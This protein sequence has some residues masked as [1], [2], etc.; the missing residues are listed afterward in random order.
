MTPVDASA[1]FT[2]SLGA[3]SAPA[4][5]DITAWQGGQ[6]RTATLDVTPGG[7]PA[8][9]PLPLGW[10]AEAQDFLRLINEYRVANG[11][12]PLALDETLQRAASWMAEDALSTCVATDS[13]SPVHDDSFGR[14][15][16][17]RLSAFGYLQ[18]AGENILWG[19][20][21]SA[22][23]AE[24]SFEGWRTSP[25]HNANMLFGAWTAIG[26][27]RACQDGEC[28]WLTD[29]GINVVDHFEPPVLPPPVRVPDLTVT[30]ISVIA[31]TDEQPVTV[32]VTVTNTGAADTGDGF[33]VHLFLDPVSPPTTATIPYAMAAFP[34]LGP[35][36]SG[37]VQWTVPAGVLAAGPHTLWA[38]VDGH[39]VITEID[40]ENNAASVALTVRPANTPPVAVDDAYS[41][42][43]DVTLA[44]AA[45]GVLGN[46]TD[47]EGNLLTAELVTAWGNGSY[48]QLG[49]G[50]YA[51]RNSPVRVIGLPPVIAIAAGSY[52]SLTIDEDRTVWAWGY[53]ANGQLGTGDFANRNTPVQVIGPGGGVLTDVSAIAG[54]YQHSVAQPPVNDSFAAAIGLALPSNVVGNTILASIEAGEPL[55]SCG[56]IG[57]TLWY[58]IVP[59]ESGILAASMGGSLFDTR[60]A[61]YSGSSLAGLVDVDCDDN[62]GLD[63]ASLLTADVTAGQA[64]YLQV[65]GVSSFPGT[66]HAGVLAL[67]VTVASR[68]VNDDFDAA[69]AVSLGSP[70]SLAGDTARATAESGEPL[71]DCG[72]TGRTVWYALT[73]GADGVLTLTVQN[74]EFQ[75]LLV[76]YAGSAVGDLA[77]AEC[78]QSGPTRLTTN[79][80]G[81]QTY[82][83]QLGGQGGSGGVFTLDS[84]FYPYPPNDNFSGAAE[85]VI[86]GST[87]GTM[88]G[89]T[90]EDDE[91]TR[92]FGGDVR[93]RNTVWYR[94]VPDQTGEL[95]LRLETDRAETGDGSGE[96]FIA[97]YS[98][99]SLPELT[100]QGSGYFYFPDDVITNIVEEGQ[101]YYLQAGIQSF[102]IPP[103]GDFLL[104]AA[105]GPTPD[106][107]VTAVATAGGPS[108]EP[109]QVSVTVTNNGNTG[110][111]TSFPLALFSGTSKPPSSEAVPLLVLTV[112]PL[113]S[114]ASVTVEAVLA[115]LLGFNEQVTL[116]VDG[117]PSGVSASFFPPTVTPPG[118]SVLVLTA[119]AG[120]A[121]GNF[122][123]VVTGTGGSV[124]QAANG[125]VALNFGLVPVCFGAFTGVVTGQVTGLPMAGILVTAGGRS[126][127]T[128]PDGRYTITGVPLGGNN[129]PMT[130]TLFAAPQPDPALWAGTASGTAICG[131]TTTID[132]QVL[133]RPTG[134]VTGVIQ[135]GFKDPVTGVITPVGPLTGAIDIGG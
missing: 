77:L 115:P 24:Q 5:V 100:L 49:N 2:V 99:G 52:S 116:A 131:V 51:D 12:G 73:P 14:T 17:E 134:G 107:A 18:G 98:G 124:T 58:R 35:A 78:G 67:R 130:H 4:P 40:E 89:S 135:E 26:I 92:L 15:L 96:L 43:E 126:A 57:K 122:P 71:L 106:I 56:A 59:A 82:Y 76:L 110:T 50:N 93:L 75:P 19:H 72:E 125:A 83:I 127:V 42:D 27:V 123:L 90:V 102:G 95:A 39:G 117:L 37:S 108:D 81:G 33:H 1:T 80:A 16:G 114:G 23:T 68:P 129:A 20:N 97:L 79:V 11:F 60:I 3:V 94:F 41:V 62:S 47:A 30:A 63:G 133:A 22:T 104:H 91:R 53:N 119:S 113:E 10:D 70:G 45:P 64:Y 66:A 48:G 55:P 132:L 86:P 112:G 105:I 65:G 88:L 128:G 121:T 25:G 54:G 34:A 28:A 61:L 84:V 13:C 46:D 69:L 111:G 29:F 38:M 120:A 32:D 87:P 109:V 21:A 8:P 9:E 6:S 31:G 103:L 74:A 85:L 36:G 118:T 101:T 44:I 7:T